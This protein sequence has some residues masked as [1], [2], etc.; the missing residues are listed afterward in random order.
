MMKHLFYHHH[1][2]FHIRYH[3]L[4]CYIDSSNSTG[5]GLLRLHRTAIFIRMCCDNRHNKNENKNHPA[6]DDGMRW[7]KEHHSSHHPLFHLA[8]VITSSSFVSKKSSIKVYNLQHIKSLISH[9]TSKLPISQ[10]LLVRLTL[11][12]SQWN[13]HA[14]A[15]PILHH[16]SHLH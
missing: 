13:P 5:D 12:W 1:F 10:L 15:Q 11:F 9:H 8:L 7:C 6:A 3:F 2:L 14:M 4:D 16:V